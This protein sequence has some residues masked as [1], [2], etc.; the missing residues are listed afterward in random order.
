MEK[1]TLM[2]MIV[3]YS[4]DCVKKYSKDEASDI[5]RNAVIEMNGGNTVLD[6]KSFRRNPALY[7]VVEETIKVARDS[8]LKQSDFFNTYVEE[9]P[10]SEMDAKRWIIK[11]DC[12]LLVSDISRGNQNVRRQRLYGG[13]RLTLNPQPHAI[14]VY[15]EWTRLMSG[16][17]DLNEMLDAMSRAIVNA[18]LED[19]Y[20]I[21]TSIGETAVGS[22]FYYGGSYAEASVLTVV[23]K[24]QARNSGAGVML[25][26][27][28]TGARK[29][30]SGIVSEL[31]REDY[32]NFG[33]VQKWNGIDLIA[34]PQRFAYGTETFKLDDNVIYVIP[35]TLEKPIKGVNADPYFKI[36]EPGENLDLTTDI[37]TI[38][39][40]QYGLLMPVTGAM[41]VIDLT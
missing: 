15:D 1:A 29:L 13:A 8:G 12:D 36:G 24:V 25:V 10:L 31:D 2:Q 6:I 33:N 27:T 11:K 32:R 19:I 3:D 9:V 16:K 26:T 7:D 4:N 28:Q 22:S 18:K 35:S 20:G 37:V 34:V 40:W 41:G 39:Q 38:E 30:T 14:T 21:W 5:V 23:Q 17:A